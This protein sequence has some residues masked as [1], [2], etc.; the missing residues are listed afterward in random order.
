ML[1][2]V[3]KRNSVVLKCVTICQQADVLQTYFLIFLTLC[4]L[5]ETQICSLKEL[6]YYIYIRYKEF[7]HLSFGFFILVS[8]TSCS[9]KLPLHIK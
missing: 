4:F 6:K 3:L 5:K 9:L 8:L 2:K 1:L 7:S